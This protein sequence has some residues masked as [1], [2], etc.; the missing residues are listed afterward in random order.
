MQSQQ[1]T[2]LAGRAL[3]DTGGGCAQTEEVLLAGLCG[4]TDPIHSPLHTR[5]TCSLRTNHHEEATAECT[6][7]TTMHVTRL[8]RRGTT[9]GRY[10]EQG[11]PA[12]DATEGSVTADSLA[13]CWSTSPSLQGGSGQSSKAPNRMGAAG[14]K[15]G[16]T[17]SQEA[18][19]A[20]GHS[21]QTGQ[22]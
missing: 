21:L 19:A 8:R 13:A 15:R 11:R 22:G 4:W 7:V 14:R 10:A 17:T 18:R 3:T 6:H 12:T 2:A 16:L 5:W 9:G 1:P 20:G